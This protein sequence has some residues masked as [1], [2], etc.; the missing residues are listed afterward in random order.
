[1]IVDDLE[2]VQRGLESMFERSEVRV[3]G[4]ASSGAEAV[5]L[6]RRHRP[7]VVLLDVRLGDEDGLDAIGPLRAAAPGVRVLILSAFDNPT[8]IARAASAGAHDY[9]S[10]TIGRTALIEAVANAARGT[11]PSR[12]GAL[13]KVS[14]AIA[15]SD[16]PAGADVPLTPRETQVLRS[17]AMGLSNREIAA[18]FGISVET[19]KEHVQKLLRKTALADRTQ[20]A[21]WAIRRGLA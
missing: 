20:A 12:E 1:L 13:R 11:I 18:T 21:V 17:L 19:V 2:V 6:A 14:A 10:K 8:Y 16:L 9:L 5:R 3:V 7:D 15:N 4:A